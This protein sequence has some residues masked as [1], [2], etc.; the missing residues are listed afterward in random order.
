MGFM[1]INGKRVEFQNEKNIL[2]VIRKMGIE[3]P[4]FCYHSELSI[5]GA[6][7]M[8]VIEDK[9][10]T[11]MASCSEKPREG[12]V[13]QTHS[14]R[15][16]KHRRMVLE[17]LLAS[18][19]RDCTTC[20][21]NG[22]CTLQELAAKMGINQVRFENTNPLLPLDQSS[23][24]M[25]RD[26]NKCILCGD[27]VRTC[28]EV[29]GVGAIGFSYRGSKVQVI[30]AFHKNLS[31]TNCVDCGQCRVACPTAALSIKFDVERAW[32]VIHNKETRVVA[33]IAPAVRVAIG[34]QFG[35][36]KGEDSLGKLVTALRYLGFDEVYDTT[37]G[38]DLTVMEEAKELLE[39]LEA[40]KPKTMFTSCCPA[41]VNY[42]EKKY[43]EFKEQLST[44]RSPQQMFGATVK[45]YFRD[46][47]K[48]KGKKTV[49][50]S[51]MPCT[52]K[53]SEILRPEH[54]T[55]GEQDIDLVLTTTEIVKMIK[56]AGVLF[57][58]LEPEAADMPFGMIS[59]GGVIF[60]VTGGVTEAVLRRLLYKENPYE[61]IEEIKYS[62]VRGQEG[63][64]E[65]TVHLGGSEVKI[66]VVSGLRNARFVLEQ[67][68]SGEVTY[69]FVEVMACR[70][71]CVMGGGQPR[72]AGE[73]TKKARSQGLYQADQ[74][75]Q[76]KRSNDNPMILALY[77]GL[78][79][80]QEQELLHNAR[81]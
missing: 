78:L 54:S 40:K 59:G 29:Q 66:C 46:E 63:I 68:K 1:T 60:G 13:I 69:D 76:V 58:Q 24:S 32:E 17:L 74:L 36:S 41:W 44:C 26:P 8:C 35:I 45:E 33:Q 9:D 79:K 14:P 31:D 6:C 50:I 27:C 42:C 5:Y 53:K 72:G 11:I 73:R 25:V 21:R 15:V 34:E 4:T 28:E 51:I 39:H 57:H 47:K 67:L 52:A 37:F 19:C 49:M 10:G 20:D 70:R 3:L 43:P 61:A 77:E 71:G 56:E 80:G 48:K 18:H 81:N 16:L 38:A 65:A 12:M 7:R 30:P 62:G 55:K 22:D 23:P 75:L 2:L 64:K